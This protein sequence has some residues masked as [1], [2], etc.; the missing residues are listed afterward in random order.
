MQ[1]TRN[2]PLS[3]TILAI[4]AFV[5]GIL[6]LL[7]SLSILNGSAI[8]SARGTDLPGQV[9][10]YGLAVLVVSALQL[11]F[12]YGAWDLK[13]W[14]WPLGII[15]QL[16]SIAFALVY[17]AIGAGLLSQIGGIVIA[18]VSLALLLTPDVRRALGKM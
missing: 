7:G 5:S 4:L 2:K 12:G 11:A 8:M 9:P 16:A 6:G 17:I 13:R 10:A 14:A 15:L 3:L 18:V 1:T